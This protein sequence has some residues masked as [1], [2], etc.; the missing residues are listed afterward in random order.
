VE[1]QDFYLAMVIMLSAVLGAI[2][3]DRDHPHAPP[4]APRAS[5]KTREL[6]DLREQVH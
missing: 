2:S 6:E 5:Q 3:P 1:V 4:E